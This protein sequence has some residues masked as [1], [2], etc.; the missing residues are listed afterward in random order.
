MSGLP[1]LPAVLVR[2]R[3]PGLPPPSILRVAISTAIVAAWI[4]YFSK[5]QR[6]R[7]TFVLS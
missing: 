5:S 4:S 1:G 6:V 7:E 3:T 2:Y